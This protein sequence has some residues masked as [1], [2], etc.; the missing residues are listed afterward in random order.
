MPFGDLPGSLRQ[1]IYDAN[2]LPGPDQIVWQT[3]R[4]RRIRLNAGELL[5][6]DDVDVIGLGDDQTTIGAIGN[7]RV[8]KIDNGD[9]AVIDVKRYKSTS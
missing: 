8:F 7:S 5:I 2:H 6:A 3:G 9:S 4:S 1:A